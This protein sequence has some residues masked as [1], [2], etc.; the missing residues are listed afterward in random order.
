MYVL[1]ANPGILLTLDNQM[2]GL[3]DGDKIQFKEIVGM[4]ALNGSTQTIKGKTVTE[5]HRIGSNR[6]DPV[7]CML[8]KNLTWCMFR[9]DLT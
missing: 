5:C 7:S 9:K 2:H 1:Q 8:R 3:E 4:T 6:K